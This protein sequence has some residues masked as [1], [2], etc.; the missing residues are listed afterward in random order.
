MNSNKLRFSLLFSLYV[1]L[2]LVRI[3]EHRKELNRTFRTVPQEGYSK[4]DQEKIDLWFVGISKA[5]KTNLS[6]FF[7]IWKLPVSDK[8]KQEVAG[9]AS[10]FPEELEAGK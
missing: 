4:S 3:W 5:A 6:R 9:Y 1:L 7:E 2:F 8:A 10:W